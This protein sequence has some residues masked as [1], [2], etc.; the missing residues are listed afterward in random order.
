MTKINNTITR[1]A[2]TGLILIPVLAINIVQAQPEGTRYLPVE[3]FKIKFTEQL[4]EMPDQKAR[5]TP[6][7]VISRAEVLRSVLLAIDPEMELTRFRPEF[8]AADTL[9][10]NSK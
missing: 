4:I 5:V 9:R 3:T 6:H 7:A 2:I 1:L 10:I 8:K